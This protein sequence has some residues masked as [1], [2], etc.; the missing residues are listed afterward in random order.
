MMMT[1]NSCT[2]SPKHLLLFIAIAFLCCWSTSSIKAQSNTEEAYRDVVAKT[3]TQELQKLSK[4]F[5]LQHKKS[6]EKALELA[7]EKGWVI[8]QEYEDGTAIELQGVD[9]FGSPIYYQTNNVIAAQSTGTD[10]VHTGGGL[11]YNLEGLGMTMGEWDQNRCRVSHQE[12]TGRAYQ[13]D[14]STASLS[15]HSTHVGVT[16]IGAGINGIAK[17]M[18]PQASLAVN[19][20]GNDE[21]EMANQAANGLLISQHSYG[22]I[23]GWYADYSNGLGEHYWYGNTNISNAEDYR[24]GVYNNHTRDW[25]M[26]GYNAP[27]YLI[28]KS[29]GN[30]RGSSHNGTHKVMSNGNWII[31][32][33]SR[34]SDGNSD[35]YDC[36]PTAAN[37]KN[38][39]TIG[40]VDDVAGGYTEASDVSMS[41]FSSWGPTDDGRIK[42]DLVGNGV[43]VLSGTS[44]SD[45]A[46]S[47]YSGTSMAGP[48]VAGSLLLVQEH[49]KNVY[50]K[51]MRAATLKGLAIHTAN[52]TGPAPGPDYMFGWGL[53]NTAGAVQHIT[54]PHDEL[55]EASLP[56]GT[57]YRKTF[58]SDG[59]KPIR[60][61]LSW[62]DVPGTVGTAA[63]N[64][65]TIKLV[66]DLDARVIAPQGNTYMPYILDPATPSAPA[67]FGDNIRDNVEHFYIEASSMGYYTVEV[68]HKGTLT[69][70]NQDFS[71]IISGGGVEPIICSEWDT[72][73]THNNNTH[74]ST[75]YNIASDAL[76]NTYASG[77]FSGNYTLGSTTLSSGAATQNYI[78]KYDDLNQVLWAQAVI[79]HDNNMIR[80]IEVDQNNNLYLVGTYVNDVTV[81]GTSF[82]NTTNK[83]RNFIA[84]LDPNGSLLWAKEIVGTDENAASGLVVDSNNDVYIA[85]H[86]YGTA[87]WDATHIHTNTGVGSDSYVAK[88]N[89]AGAIQWVQTF[90]GSASDAFYALAIDQN[91]NLVAGGM[92]YGTASYGGPSYNS[93]G[94]A[95]MVV[96]RLSSANGTAQWSKQIAGTGNQVLSH[97]ST[98]ISNAVYIAGTY[99]NSITFADNTHNAAASLNVILAKYDENGYEQWAV[100]FNSTNNVTVG[101]LAVDNYTAYLTA[102]FKATLAIGSSGVIGPASGPMD[103]A[104]ASINIA[105]GLNTVWHFGGTGTDAIYDSDW[106]GNR[107]VS[108]GMFET[109]MTMGAN[110]LTTSNTT[111][112]FVASMTKTPLPTIDLGADLQIPCGATP[113]INANLVGAT[114][115]TWSPTQGLSDPNSLNVVLN[116]DTTVIYTLEATNSCGQKAFDKIKVELFPNQGLTVDAG[117]DTSFICGDTIVLNATATGPAINLIQWSPTNGVSHP[118]ILTPKISHQQGGINYTLN[119]YNVCGG[120]VTD[121]VNVANILPNIIPDAGVDTSVFCGEGVQLNASATGYLNFTYYWYP[122]TTLSSAVG[123]NPIASPTTNTTYNVYVSG[124]NTTRSSSVNVLVK[125]IIPPVALNANTVY[126]TTSGTSYQWYKDGV[127]ING[128]TDSSWLASNSGAGM[129]TVELTDT[130]GCTGISDPIAYL[131]TGNLSINAENNFELIPNPNN[132]EFLVKFTASPQNTVQAQ[133]FDATGKILHQQSII[134][135]NTNFNL[136]DLPKG[137]YILRLTSKKDVWTK[138]F[139]KN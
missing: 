16:M 80:K 13:A 21:S 98:D 44:A 127:V 117:P 42:P 83:Q 119:I 114:N 59:Q 106:N 28:V 33:A 91:D 84:K 55:V 92:F 2:T 48:N 86:F 37:A 129:Y 62:T 102:N 56:D 97:I 38:I 94:D 125:D 7:K 93:A 49:H 36:L 19:S 39:L 128:A 110:T 89:S 22:S 45:S 112:A 11:G 88:Y 5:D 50:N 60:V 111:E 70:S 51:F 90:G 138:R 113:S 34:N 52:E 64:D 46:Y 27:Y 109:S 139:I 104:T 53:L 30:D 41:S 9:E 8:K 116:N 72:A 136:I 132:G 79:G 40:A 54:N 108:T 81:A 68:T 6:L 61:T 78:V 63:L 26:I 31:S 99:Q 12:F 130:N 76:G 105:G 77:L 73:W 35:G 75:G 103:F 122:N 134:D 123:P 25:D 24:F 121:V 124:C 65:N 133:I 135:A 101:D 82:S 118:N 3:N 67:T 32:T 29:A 115:F 47:S 96:L 126:T 71:L 66:H 120:H 107:F 43:G 85:G 100:P 20:W 10:L 15:S 14:G 131:M 69:T 18:A 95:D 23:T 1:I 74:T 17:G 4:R 87:T 137:L 57:T 58:Y